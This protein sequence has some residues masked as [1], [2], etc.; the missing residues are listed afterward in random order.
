MIS[1][2]K[3]HSV[4]IYR[5]PYPATLNMDGT[6]T[7]SR[8]INMTVEG[9]LQ[10]YQKGIVQTA[11]PSGYSVEDS[12]IFFTK[13]KLNTSSQTKDLKPDEM[14]IDGQVFFAN[15]SQPFTGFGLQSDHYAVL[16]LRE[17]V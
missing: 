10:P 17:G 1:L 13:E 5:Y 14:I 2:L 9:S 3:T 7:D 6:F 16:F 11:L 15:F 8:K 12:R 4:T